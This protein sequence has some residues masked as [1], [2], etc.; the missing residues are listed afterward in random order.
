MSA[1]FTN[2]YRGGMALAK[3]MRGDN[4][5]PINCIYIEFMNVANP[6]DDVAVPSA[7]RAEGLEYY[8]NLAA[9]RDF[10]RAPIVGP[11]ELSIASGYTPYFGD[12]EGNTL[13][14][15]S[16]TAAVAGEL[17]R[18]FA[19]SSNSKVYGLALVCVSDWTD[20]SKD[21]VVQRAYYSDGAEQVL[22]PAGNFQVKYPLTFGA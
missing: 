12:G 13:V 2:P 11:S 6:G 1:T 15:R 16:E 3:Q 17:G 9:D 10:I 21:I 22:K 7:T 19:N 8:D 14:L 4:S 20:R 5:H 18:A